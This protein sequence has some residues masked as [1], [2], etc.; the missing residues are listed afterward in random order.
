MSQ[1]CFKMVNILFLAYL[2]A[3]FVTIAMLNVKLIPDL[4]TCAIVQMWHPGS[5]IVL[6]CID[7]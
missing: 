4:Y 1:I 6:D 7:S 2:A 3:N 5:G